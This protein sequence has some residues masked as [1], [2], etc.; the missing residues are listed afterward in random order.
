LPAITDPQQVG[1]KQQL[2]DVF[3]LLAVTQ[4]PLM[5]TMKKGGGLDKLYLSIRPGS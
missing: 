1:K 5:S 2:S 3:Y 4:T